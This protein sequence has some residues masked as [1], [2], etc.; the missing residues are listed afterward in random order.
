MI[1]DEIIDDLILA[2][3]GDAKKLDEIVKGEEKEEEDEK[4]AKYR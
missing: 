4:N 1:L 2:S 3:N